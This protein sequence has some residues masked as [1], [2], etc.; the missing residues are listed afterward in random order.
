MEVTR[1]ISKEGVGSIPREI[2][3][4]RSLS[5]LFVAKWFSADSSLDSFGMNLWLKNLRPWPEYYGWNQ[6]RYGANAYAAKYVVVPVPGSF[7]HL[8]PKLGIV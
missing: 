3:M 6:L 5:Q 7:F 2:I 1:S 8:D 4:Y